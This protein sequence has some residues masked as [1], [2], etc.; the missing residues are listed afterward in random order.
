MRLKD[1]YLKYKSIFHNLSYMAILRVFM[2]ILPLITYP[3]LIRVV[4]SKNYGL[5]VYTLSI[6]A[7]F[8][9]FVKFGFEMSAV[10]NIAQNSDDIAKKSEII[11]STL[12][13]QMF[14][15]LLGFSFLYFLI[16]IIPQF[17]ENQKLVY[18]AYLL[19]LCD[20]LFLVWFFQGIEKMK[21]ITVVNVIAGIIGLCLIFIFIREPEDYI[22]IPLFQAISLLI[23]ATYSLWLVLKKENI[24]FYIP[25]KNKILFYLKES[26]S[27][28]I[29]RSSAVFNREIN[30]ILLANF[31]SMNSVAFYD[32]A[33]KIIDVFKMPNSIINQVV[34]PYISKNKNKVLAKKI[35]FIRI[36]IAVFLMAIV[37]FFGQFFILFL[38]G[39][40][41]L[42]A[43]SILKLFNFMLLFTAITYYTGSTLLVAFGYSN[44]FNISVIYSTI[45]FLIA[46]LLMYIS[47]FITITNVVFLMLTVETYLMIYRYYYCKRYKIL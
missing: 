8:R 4:G 39:E 23:G 41:M 16:Q 43:I 29:S 33:K 40:S 7:F 20:I 28:F 30:T 13:I 5:V 47:N 17:K 38:G 24:T 32:L 25:S 44:K 34:Y 10:K 46:V 31:A 2:L 21:Y 26:F 15:Y 3:Y 9:I 37:Y 35:F 1:I 14:F 22:Y 12:I 18:F 27:F 45:L 42:G 36:I 6:I 19:P 11:S